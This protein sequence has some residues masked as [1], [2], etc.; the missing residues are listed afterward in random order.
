V[1]TYTPTTGYTGADS[2]T[3]KANNGS[4]DSNVATVS[5][6]VDAPPVAAAQNVTAV[7]NTAL[8]ITLSATDPDSP[9]LTFTVTANPSNGSLGAVGTP[10]CTPAGG[11]SSCTATVTYTPNPGFFGADSFQFK[12]ND[13]TV[14]SNHATV[15]ITVDAP[16]VA[17]PQSVTI[18]P[19]TALPITLAATDSDS[20]SLT[21]A[22][23]AN[24]THGSLGTL[25]VPSC[26]PAG[27]AVAARQR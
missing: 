5:I 19:N 4:V 8:P 11:G 27:G 15:S 13:G 6:T 26:S 14:D 7:E 1:V 2:F 20:P 24:P 12:V 16:P 17:D 3:F 23:V 10:T 22:I 18:A 25:G 9:S 21:F